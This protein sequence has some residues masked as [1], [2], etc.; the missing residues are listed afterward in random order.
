MRVPNL[1]AYKELPDRVNLGVKDIHLVFGYTKGIGNLREKIKDGSI[2]KQ[3][4]YRKCGFPMKGNRPEWNLGKLRK[5]RDN[6]NNA[7]K[8]V[9]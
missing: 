7:A 3:D 6:M 8:G 2:P 4:G 9:I 1:D 5:L